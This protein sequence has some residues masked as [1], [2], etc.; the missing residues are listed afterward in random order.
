[1]VRNSAP[2]VAL[3]WCHFQRWSCFA[4]LMDYKEKTAP[5]SKVAPFSKMAPGF[6]LHFFLSVLNIRTKIMMTIY[7]CMATKKSFRKRKKSL[8]TGL[9]AIGSGSV[10]ESTSSFNY[11]I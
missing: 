10:N 1:M 7:E 9:I 3:S 11:H 8:I 4:Q 5:P 2:P 6:W